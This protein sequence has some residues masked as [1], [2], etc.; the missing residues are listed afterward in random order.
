MSEEEEEEKFL[1]FYNYPMRV[2]SCHDENG[3]STLISKQFRFF[4][5]KLKS[6]KYNDPK[7]GEKLVNVMDEMGMKRM[8]CR[9]KFANLPLIPM[10]TRSKNR[11]YNDV[12]KFIITEDTRE[13]GFKVPPPEFPIL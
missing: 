1:N 10:I 5:E 7:K 9:V 6:V 4:Y 2:C 13:L 12:N 3:D 11:V 8:C